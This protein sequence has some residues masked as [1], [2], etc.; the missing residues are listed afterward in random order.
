MTVSTTATKA[1]FNGSWSTGPFTFSFRFFANSE[2]AVI[3]TSVA[4]VD[5]TLTETTHY[6][7]TGATS[8]TGG[9]IT[10]GTALASGETLTVVR[11]LPFTQEIDLRN[12]GAFFAETIEEG[13]DRVTM[14][15]QQLDEILGRTPSMAVTA[16]TSG[17]TV[18]VGSP[19]AYIQWDAAGTDFQNAS[20]PS[21]GVSPTVAVGT[22]TGVANGSPATVTNSG[23]SSAAVFD[24]E[25]PAGTTGPAGDGVPVG[26]LPGQILRWNGSAWVPSVD[27]AGLV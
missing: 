13:F 24:F 6:T 2:I 1:T 14:L 23:S 8:Y 18:P 27:L 11:T 20:P 3:K 5:T 22:V 15:V 12:Q 7:L 9:S 10:L 25:I 16:Q 17:V 4:G 21:D 19:L 26:T